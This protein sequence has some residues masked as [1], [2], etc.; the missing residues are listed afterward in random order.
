MTVSYSPLYG[1][2]ADEKLQPTYSVDGDHVVVHSTIYGGGGNDVITGEEEPLQRSRY[3]FYGEAGDDTLRIDSGAKAYFSGGKGNDQIFL[4]GRDQQAKGGDGYDTLIA[5]E[6]VISAK[7]AS[8]FEKLVLEGDAFLDGVGIGSFDEVVVNYTTLSLTLQTDLST[9][10]IETSKAS[11][12]YIKGSNFSDRFDGSSYSGDFGVVAGGGN[13]YVK[14]NDNGIDADGGS[15]ND[16]LIGGSGNDTPWDGSAQ[17]REANTMIGGSGN[18]EINYTGGRGKIDGGSGAD[19]LSLYSSADRWVMNS[20]V[21]K[22]IEVLDISFVDGKLFLGTMDTSGLRRLV[23]DGNIY[24]SN[25]SVLRNIVSEDNAAITGSAGANNVSIADV[26]LGTISIN[27]RGGD[28]RLSVAAG[29][30][31]L[32]G[33]DGDDRLVGGDDMA[34][35]RGGDG[36]DV[37]QG[38]SA[39]DFLN[40]QAGND[41]LSGGAGNDTL[42]LT[43]ATAS[44][45][46]IAN[47]GDGKDLFLIGHGDHGHGR[48]LGGAGADLLEGRGNLAGYV[49]RDIETLK[50]TGAITADA[51]AFDSFSKIVSHDVTLADSQVLKLVLSSGG[52]FSWKAASEKTNGVLTGSA[53]ADIINFSKS[54]WG[55]HFELGKGEDV[56]TGTQARDGFYFRKGDGHDVIHGF[57]DF[58]ANEDSI[59]I[60]STAKIRGIEDLDDRILT[61]GD[62]V[63]IVLDDEVSNNLADMHDVIELRNVNVHSI[64]SMDIQI[65]DF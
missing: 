3:A 28:D 32:I 21:V 55:W 65:Y 12:F 10:N 19:T 36:D 56:V 37:I 57:K 64:G 48:I 50:S 22:S 20:A 8:G 61:R 18:D 63:L 62:D 25:K 27:G 59:L 26:E 23:G 47:G 52:H 43:D 6:T 33:G 60:H 29:Q 58:G 40:G 5:A 53:Q 46:E 35:I 41:T 4:T 54:T 51:D 17:N 39:A 49:V 44:D 24:M 13:D 15:G 9:V 42:V 45:K 30:A 1:S 14:G 2:D 11:M 31:I 38:G 34:T 16:I 7:S